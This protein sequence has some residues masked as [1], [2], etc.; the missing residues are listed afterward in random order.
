MSHAARTTSSATVQV[1][2]DLS[3]GCVGPGPPQYLATPPSNAQVGSTSAPLPR[4]QSITPN[5]SK[6]TKLPGLGLLSSTEWDVA[7][8]LEVRF[9]CCHALLAQAKRVRRLIHSNMCQCGMCLIALEAHPF[10]RSKHKPGKMVLYVCTT[11]QF[12][13]KTLDPAHIDRKNLAGICAAA[14]GLADL[15]HPDPSSDLGTA[16]GSHILVP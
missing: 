12:P 5:A 11:L 6:R 7:S 9:G 8:N 16:V 13:V 2:W 4:L 1:V 10:L 15:V 14:K 3:D